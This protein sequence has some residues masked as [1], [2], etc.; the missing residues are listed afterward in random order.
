MIYRH[1]PKCKKSNQV[2]AKSCAKCG[3]TLSA[4]YRVIIVEKGHRASR[5]VDSLVMA[6][7]IESAMKADILR[8]EFNILDHRV[9]KSVTLNDIWIEYLPSIQA[10]NKAWKDDFRNYNKHIQ[11]VFGDMA[12]DDIDYSKIDKFKL[13]FNGKLNARGK[14][15]EPATIKHQIVLLRRLFNI[16]IK[17]GK[18]QGL[19]PVNQIDM[20]VIDNEIVTYL[21]DSQFEKLKDTLEKWPVKQSVNLIK[22][23]VSTGIRRGEAFSLKWTD[24]DIER[25]IMKIS[26]PKGRKTVSIPLNDLAI[27]ILNGISKTDESPYVFPGKDGAKLTDISCWKRIKKAADIPK[28]FR[29]HDL[30]HHFASMLCWNGVDIYVVSKLLTHKDVSTTLKYAHLNNETMKNGSDKVIDIFDR[31]QAENIG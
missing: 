3:E 14:N 20:P 22:F 30:R 24:L 1:C 27:E 2:K 16:A 31:K 25:G 4:K 17:R 13:S 8:G 29:L 11:P 7:E 28:D 23:L 26:K 9:K 10:T 21:S 18:Y 19:N 15:Y 12:L 5:V 6:R